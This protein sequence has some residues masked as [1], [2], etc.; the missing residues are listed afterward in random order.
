M[1]K[2]KVKH[3]SLVK[4]LDIE[5]NSSVAYRNETVTNPIEYSD[6]PIYQKL[7]NF[8]NRNEKKRFT[9]DDLLKW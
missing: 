9:V 5:Q 3:L 4:D 6:N 8:Q 2:E 1:K 7:L